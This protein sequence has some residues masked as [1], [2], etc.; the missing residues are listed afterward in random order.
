MNFFSFIFQDWAANK[1]STKGRLI[2]L[3]FRI[4]NV[5]TTQKT[6]YYLGF[7]YRVFYKILVEWIFCIEIPWN[8]KIGR[9]LTIYHGQGIVLS[10]Q[11]V[12]GNHCTLRHYTTIGNKQAPG[13]GHTASPVIGNYVDMGCNTCI[14]GDI[15]IGD[16]VTI[17]CGSVVTKS[18]PANIVAAGNPAT[19]IKK[20]MTAVLA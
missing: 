17:G 14:I 4:A 6:Y 9:G 5:G 2:T 15:T 13:G 16:H 1:T 20:R 19:E 7:P 11:V 10:S 8:V 18:I 12:M 3:L